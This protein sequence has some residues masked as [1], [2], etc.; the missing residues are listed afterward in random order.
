VKVSSRVGATSGEADVAPRSATCDANGIRAVVRV[1]GLEVK[2]DSRLVGAHNLDNLLLALGVVC[3]LDLDVKRAAEALSAEAGA[4]GRLERCDVAGD[5]ITVLVDYAHTPDALGRV[6]DAARAVTRGRVFC[7][8]GCG[9]DRDASKRAPMG[10]AV[11]RRADVAIITNDNPRTERPEAIAEPIEQ[12]ARSGGMRPVHD[13]DDGSR[14]Y[15][16]ELDRARA[17]GRAIRAARKGDL[18]LLAGKG[19]E[20]YQVVGTEKRPFDDRGEAR[21]ALSERRARS[22]S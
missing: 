5:D 8:F 11:A 20:D 16:V 17:I 15:V 10:A 4:P 7:V 1:P 9:G 3:A 22:G 14:G 18:V 12:G 2:L 19:H 6:L 21:R 13:L